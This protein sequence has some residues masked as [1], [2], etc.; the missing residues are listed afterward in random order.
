MHS[1]ISSC[2]YR[3]FSEIDYIIYIRVT[4]LDPDHQVKYQ[5]TP[6]MPRE[7]KEVLFPHASTD[8][9]II[10]HAF[11]SMK[12]W[13]TFQIDR[14]HGNTGR[15]YYIRGSKN[16]PWISWQKGHDASGK[17]IFPD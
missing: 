9:S 14:S 3:F 1:N 10:F 16:K 12:T 2:D 4:Y 15:V 5:I 7:M 6:L 17:K 8:I 13:M 11:F